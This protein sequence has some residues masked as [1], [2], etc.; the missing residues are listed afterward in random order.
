MGT[1]EVQI[2][3]ERIWGHLIEHW[4][5]FEEKVFA[6]KIIIENREIYP[7]NKVSILFKKTGNIATLSMT[8]LAWM[9]VENNPESEDMGAESQY[10]MILFDENDLELVEDIVKHFKSEIIGNE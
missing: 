4:E 7:L 10:S 1:S 8:P 6:K 3:D 9:V 5:T 2:M